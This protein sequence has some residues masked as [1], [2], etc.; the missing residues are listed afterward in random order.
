M[1]SFV[2]TC[3]HTLGWVSKL[4][5]LN[6]FLQQ[7]ASLPASL[8]FGHL[9]PLLLTSN[10]PLINPMTQRAWLLPTPVLHYQILC[11]K[12]SQTRNIDI[13]ISVQ[14]NDF[15]ASI[16]ISFLIPLALP[17]SPP[18]LFEDGLICGFFHKVVLYIRP[19]KLRPSNPYDYR[20]HPGILIPRKVIIQTGH[21]KRIRRI[22]EACTNLCH[23]EDAKLTIR[24]W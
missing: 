16:P 14:H 4:P 6:N 18:K 7:P 21:S 1:S 22:G 9:S 10:Q 17:N 19:M 5:L 20:R 3:V 8:L 12:A 11:S 23:P 13:L 24:S 2:A 15:W